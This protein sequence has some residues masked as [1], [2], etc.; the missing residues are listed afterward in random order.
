M[1]RKMGNRNQKWNTEMLHIFEA[2]TIRHIGNN[3][4]SFELWFYRRMSKVSWSQHMTN[5]EILRRKKKASE[6]INT[7][8]RRKMSYFGHMLRSEKYEL[9]CDQPYRGR[10][11][12]EEDRETS[13]VLTEN[14]KTAE[15]KN[16]SRTIQNSN[17]QSKMGHDD[18]QCLQMIKH[19]KKKK[20][21]VGSGH[22]TFRRE[23]RCCRN[24]RY[25]IVGKKQDKKNR[26]FGW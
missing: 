26:N 16:S 22:N 12:K 19:A 3:P 23:K 1:Q 2:Q 20:N 18:R 7:V 15:Q 9:I 11:K 17:K 24:S 8:N 5:T 6:I 10:W 25:S 13:L 4:S 14:P 21:Y